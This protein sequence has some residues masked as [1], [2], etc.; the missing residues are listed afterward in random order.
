M[1]A[2]P[3][4][5]S[6][7]LYYP[8]I[9]IHDEG[10]LRSALCIWDR[11]YR[12]VPSTY[13]PED[14]EDIMHALDAG[15]LEDLHL[16]VE[17]TRATADNFIQFLESLPSIPAF[18]DQPGDF[19]IRIHPEKIDQKLLPV[20]E[21]L[22][23]KIDKDGW[24]NLSPPIANSYMLFLANSVSNR[25]G[26]PKVTNDQ[27]MFT[28]MHFFAN[29]GNIRDFVFDRN[30]EDASTALIMKLLL[31]GGLY[32]IDMKAFIRLRSGQADSR[33]A[34]RSSIINLSSRIS[35]IEEK[36]FVPEIIQ[37][38]EDG[39]VQAQEQSLA[40][41][42]QTIEDA[43]YSLLS[44]GLPTALGA[45]SLFSGGEDPF[46]FS[47]LGKAALIGAVAAIADVASSRRKNW[48][49]T[50]AFYFMKL[51]QTYE[52]DEDIEFS[53]P[54]YGKLMDELIND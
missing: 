28:T 33:E 11:I 48:R 27:Y 13:Q 42:G 19:D 9:E 20:L 4:E 3:F 37:E 22:A 21:D 10:W 53:V 18:L 44:I 35:L 41:F 5:S 45:I 15:L 24:L 32:H 52:I 30:A 23:N 47:T 6:S 26:I 17:D 7:A 46:N 14:S 40:S 29:D 51:L 1:N 12:I 50:D 36:S 25:R 38:F 8:E 31:P 2:V 39:L 43:A 34:F 16:S 54:N 49:S